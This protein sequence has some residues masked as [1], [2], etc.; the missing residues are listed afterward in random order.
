M[1]QQVYE[2]LYCAVYRFH[3]CATPKSFIIKSI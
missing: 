1:A 3:A 2:Y